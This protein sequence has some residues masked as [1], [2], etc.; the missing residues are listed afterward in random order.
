VFASLIDGIQEA[1][2]VI[3]SP[4]SDFDWNAANSLAEYAE[5]EFI[6]QVCVKYLLLIYNIFIRINSILFRFL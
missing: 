5:K 2:L 4:V 6:P 1:Q 3:T